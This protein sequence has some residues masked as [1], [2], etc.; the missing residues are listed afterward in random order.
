[1][2]KWFQSTPSWRGRRYVYHCYC[3]C[4]S[5]FNPRPREEGDQ[6]FYPTSVRWQY[7]NPRPREEGDP[8]LRIDSQSYKTISIHAL[9]KRATCNK[10]PLLQQRTYFN[11][12]PREEGDCTKWR[13]Y[14]TYS[15]FQSTPSWR[16]RLTVLLLVYQIKSF[17]STPSWR[18]RPSA[19]KL[20]NDLLNF[21][22]RPREEGD[23]KLNRICQVKDFISIH[24]LVKRAT[25][26]AQNSL[27]YVLFQSTPSW[28]GRHGEFIKITDRTNISIHALVKRAT[29]VACV[30]P[31]TVV[32]SIHALVKRATQ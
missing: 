28:R 31:V 27:K 8:L 17:Q 12:R 15:T 23:I 22:P 32:I 11:P 13:T 2:I 30:Y 18:G 20:R 24:A 5:D 29:S 25:T 19:E 1:M 7:F 9:V 3:V 10:Q 16:G 6:G 4:R 26:A 21:N 14:T